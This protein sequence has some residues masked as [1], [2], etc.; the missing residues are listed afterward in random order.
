[1][2]LASAY[3]SE[4]EVTAGVRTLEEVAQESQRTGNVMVA[5]LVYANLAELNRKLG[6]LHQAQDYY[7]QAIELATDARGRHLPVACRPLAGLGD[8]KREWNDLETASQYLT[9]S[10]ALSQYWV[11]AGFIFTLPPMIR[12][13][14]AQGAWEEA[15]KI[16]DQ[17]RK[18]A[19][20]FTVT[21]LD[22]YLVEMYQAWL[23][24]VRGDL[25][26]AARWVE[27]YKI[28]ESIDVLP[29]TGV[30]AFNLFHMRK[31]EQLIL[32]RLYLAQNEPA[33]A[34]CLLEALLPKFEKIGRMVQV[35]EIR[36]LRSLAWQA[37]GRMDEALAE[38]GHALKL[39]KQEGY[40]RLFL[41][42]GNQILSLLQKIKVEDEGL[43]AYSQK[44]MAGFGDGSKS[45]ALPIASLPRGS[46]IQ[47]SSFEPL[48]QREREVLRF[49]SGTLSADEIA[50]ELFVSV[51]T[52]RSH[53][54]SI[55]S[56]LDVHSR[57]EAVEKAKELKL[58]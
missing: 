57:L 35:I 42:E 53:L 27:R 41:D 25:R 26:E 46:S 6:Q 51:H 15:Q 52:V 18:A 3:L 9:E 33:E 12:V 29:A 4:Y 16:I 56:K 8:L 1:M 47:P 23:W 10:I 49:L 36:I 34:L 44:L 37:L 43:K 24:I 54:K 55:Y 5:V 38:F 58:L 39:A 50:D 32:A 7:K 19:A 17:A 13:R 28:K 30:E 40:I 21:L 45:P 11:Q 2:S 22:D 48:S 14:M 20:E 31:Y